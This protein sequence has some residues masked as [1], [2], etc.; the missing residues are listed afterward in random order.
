MTGPN[1][2]G[3]PNETKQPEHNITV[4]PGNLR[5]FFYTLTQ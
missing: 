2:Y 1:C 3:H 5:G 4:S